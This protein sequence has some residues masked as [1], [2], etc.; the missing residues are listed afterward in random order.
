MTLPR[1][2]VNAMP[3]TGRVKHL[4][5]SGLMVTTR[6]KRGTLR[7]CGKSRFPASACYPEPGT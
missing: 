1:R 6:S 5:K 7:S 2:Q 4:S 3:S